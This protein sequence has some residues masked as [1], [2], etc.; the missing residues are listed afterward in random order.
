VRFAYPGYV[1]RPVAINVHTAKK[2]NGT[3][4]GG[5]SEMANP[6]TCRCYPCPLRRYRRT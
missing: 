1:E 5:A 3:F 2:R 4:A 6:L